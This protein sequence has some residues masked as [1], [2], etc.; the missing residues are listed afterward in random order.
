CFQEPDPRGL[1]FFFSS[2]YL[3][4]GGSHSRPPFPFFKNGFTEGVLKLHFFKAWRYQ[5]LRSIG[6]I[7]MLL[8]Y[9]PNHVSYGELL[10]KS[11]LIERD[12][13]PMNMNIHII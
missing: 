1:I 3:T 8:F 2:V 9:Y 10:K 4:G 6:G 7:A 13:L 5:M 12:F 11:C